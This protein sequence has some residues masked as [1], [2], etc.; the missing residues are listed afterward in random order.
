[1]HTKTTAQT[2]YC[3]QETYKTSAA[4][5]SQ[6]ISHHV[7]NS[8]SQ[9]HTQPLSHNTQITTTHTKLTQHIQMHTKLTKRMQH[10]YSALH[11]TRPTTSLSYRAH[12]DSTN[13][14]A[15]TNNIHMHTRPSR[16]EP[17]ITHNAQMTQPAQH[18]PS[19]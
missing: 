11:T 17:I 8:N 15:P 3:T 12:A 16:G 1:M 9:T 2:T 7:H 4:T 10:T 13:E 6:H 14:Y 5:H 19:M 18:L